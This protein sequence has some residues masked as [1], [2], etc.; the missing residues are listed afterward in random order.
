MDKGEPSLVPEWL[1]SSGHA[2]GG[3]SSNHLLVSSSSHSDS[4]SLPHNSRNRN[5]RSKSDVDSIHSPFLDR[6]CSTNSRRGS[7]NGSAK[8][9]YSSFNFNRSQRDKDRGRDKDRVSYV[10]PWDLDTSI[11]VKN[12]LTGRDQDQLRR[13]HSMVTRKLGDNLSR[14]FSVGL[15][16]GGSSS[17]YNGNDILH[18]PSIG[19]SFQRTG[20]DKDFP[21]LGAEEKHGGQDV[22]RVSSPG[23]SSAVQSLPVGTSSLIGGEGWTSALAEVPNVIEKACAGSLTS[24]KANVVSTGTLTGPTG[25][26]MAEA[27]AQ[28]PART[29]TPPQG[30]VKTQ[31]L[32][33]LAIKQSRQLIPVVP[34]APKCSILNSSD[35]SKTKQVLRAG[36]TCLAPSRNSQQQPSIILGNLLSNPSG[37]IKSEKK[38]LVLKPAR[39][40]GVAAVKESGSPIGIPNSR[41]ASSH[42]MNSAQSIQSAPVRSTNSPKE[43]KG[44]T[45]LTMASGQTI[46]KKSSAAQTQSRNAFYS[47]LK[48]K[49]TSTNIST[50]PVNSTSTC[51]SFSVGEKVNTSK[52]LVA[53][54]SSSP[55]GTSCLE[56]SQRNTTGFEAAD[57]PDE[58]EAEFLRSLGWDENNGEDEALTE[59]EIKA[60]VEQYKKLRPSLP[61][62]LSIIQEAREDIA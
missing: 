59:E 49:T 35:K 34:S 12:I 20:F 30:S 39:E 11:P 7:S 50:N 53:S 40:N 44:A 32:E 41:V 54:D 25:L 23:L 55:Q 22:V 15:K 2:S 37:Q 18:G 3:G 26:N 43:P 21:S 62:K 57:T 14:G 38:L 58:K 19:N 51:I 60:F 31:R 52:E 47:A 16:N 9:P 33:D 5:S 8:H 36:E 29:H 17:S 6:S 46:E 24:P 28:A 13:S 56:V 42:L 61:Q 10:D 4:A 1:R 45:T 48:Q 27:L